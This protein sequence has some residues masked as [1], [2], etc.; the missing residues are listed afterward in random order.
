MAINLFHSDLTK[1]DE[2]M[3]LFAII[4]C[5]DTLQCGGTTIEELER[6]LFSPYM[7]QMLEKKKGNMKIIQLIQEGCELEDIKSL[8]PHSLDE[9]ITRLKND[10]INIIND[11]DIY[12]GSEF[13]I[14]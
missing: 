2:K 7:V 8:L 5:L 10:A 6:A 3:L 1:T 11:Y 4:G 14:V 13:W 12:D 9:T